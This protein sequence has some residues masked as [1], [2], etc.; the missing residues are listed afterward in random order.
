MAT[1]HRAVERGITY[2]DTAP[3][4]GAGTSESIFGAALAEGGHRQRVTLAT[5]CRWNGTAQDVLDSA[6]ASLRR[7]RTDV[8][9]VLQ[10]HGGMFRP[11]D[12]HHILEE[13]PL[14]ALRRLRERGTVRFLGFTCEEPWTARPLIASGAFD[15]V[16]LRYN[17]IYQG[18]ALHALDEAHEQGMGVA[19]MRP[20]TSGILQRALRFLKPE[21][22]EAEVYELALK[23]VLADSR[24]HV[25]NVGMRWP[26]EVDQNV[27]LAERSVPRQGST[28]PPSPGRRRGSTGRG[29]G[30]GGG[31]PRHR[32]TV[33]AAPSFASTS[34]RVR[35]TATTKQLSTLRIYQTASPIPGASSICSNMSAN[36]VRSP[37]SIVF[38][39]CRSR[40]GADRC[41]ED[42]KDRHGR[43]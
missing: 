3:G 35:S 31:G 20:L 17:L 40:A 18:A 39:T 5:K 22:P 7:L 8:L 27:D 2:L 36:S 4:Y 32:R 34:A 24:V 9:D 38:T 41:D 26:R 42:G 15:V 1:I 11:E 29:R 14:D 25:A 21:W 13:G 37:S 43:K 28:S 19:V 12:V 6:E 16:Q 23:Y 33:R 30:C 10:F